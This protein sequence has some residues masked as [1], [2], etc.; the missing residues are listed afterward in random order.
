VAVLSIAW[1][2][3]KPWNWVW[4]NLSFHSGWNHLWSVAEEVRFY[5][6]FPLV[7]AGLALLPSRRYRIAALFILILLAWKFRG[8][9]RVDAMNGVSL[10]FY[11]YFFFF[12]TGTAACLIYRALERGGAQLGYSIDVLIPLAVAA[13]LNGWAYPILS[14]DTTEYPEMWCCIF[15]LL[16]VGT[17]ISQ[18][19][20]TA[21][22]LRS[23]IMRHIGLL[24][25]SL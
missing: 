19:A 25:C 7:V 22:L 14:G 2:T 11:F 16:L 15:V 10:A 21:R 8:L 6:L 17:A 3:S 23:W 1:Q 13:V 4:L 12:L 20:F 9:H 5:F 24:S 18:S